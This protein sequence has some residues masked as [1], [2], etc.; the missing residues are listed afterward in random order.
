MEVSDCTYESQA[1]RPG[2]RTR[3]NL[4]TRASQI[5]SIV[6]NNRLKRFQILGELTIP[7]RGDSV[8]QDKHFAKL[9]C[10][11]FSVSE[12]EANFRIFDRF[13]HR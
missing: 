9:C 1:P 6:L 13:S 11:Q 10:V 3:Q 8:E 2:L 12:A 7:E 4:L 5:V